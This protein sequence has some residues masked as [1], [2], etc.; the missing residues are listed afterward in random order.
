MVNTE[1]IFERQQ[2]TTLKG[3]LPTTSQAKNVALDDEHAKITLKMGGERPLVEERFRYWVLRKPENST[4]SDSRRPVVNQDQA[5]IHLP[6]LISPSSTTPTTS[7][8]S[9]FRAN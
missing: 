5:Q 3:G 4:T 8:S 1:A 9:G 6:I 2:N 7:A